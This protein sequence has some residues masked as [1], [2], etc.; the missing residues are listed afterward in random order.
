MYL[1]HREFPGIRSIRKTHQM[2][3]TAPT[4][5]KPFPNFLTTR[6]LATALHVPIATIYKWLATG[7]EPTGAAH[8]V[9]RYLLWNE[10]LVIEWLATRITT[11]AVTHA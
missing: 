8:R 7:T 2:T 1:V 11:K 3:L 6:E 9:G 10:A 5:L 4:E